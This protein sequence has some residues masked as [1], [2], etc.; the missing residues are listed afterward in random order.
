MKKEILF[1][2]ITL[3]V[4]S[5]FVSCQHNSLENTNNDVKT[6]TVA[7]IQVEYNGQETIGTNKSK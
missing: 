4:M 5:C 2:I 7:S 1:S 6:D 3:F